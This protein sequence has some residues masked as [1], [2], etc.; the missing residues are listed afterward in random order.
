[1]GAGDI[2]TCGQPG[3]EATA[4]LLD[5]IPGTVYTAGD[6][7]YASGTASEYA[8]CY[9]PSWGR[10][11]ARTKPVPG[12]HDYNTSGASGYYGTVASKGYYSYN[13]GDWHVVALNSNCDYVDC[14]ATS[15]Q[16]QWLKNDLLAN[17]RACTA[18]VFHHPLFSSGGNHAPDT[19]VKP[20]WDA[21]YAANA[22]LIVNGHDHMYE[23]FAPQ[24]PSGA[25]DAARGI[26]EFVAG[27]GGRD[28][29]RFFGT[30]RPNSEVRNADTF[31][32]LKLT[33][34]PT[35][36]D[37]KFVPEAGKSFTDSGTTN[38]H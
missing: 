20:L 37:W 1:V 15:A 18:A 8:N 32:V 13:V 26:R 34:H 3:S 9:G 38:C 12:N 4:K 17:P 21:L 22:D 28:S 29:N 2:A 6:G 30:I 35:S 23:R 27:M 19:R 14:S 31:G 33:L 10:H 16:V 25:Y 7:A 11:K 5:N 24:N 36:Y